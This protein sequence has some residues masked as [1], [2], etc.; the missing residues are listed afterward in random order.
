MVYI[1]QF[2]ILY[3]YYLSE[4]VTTV[5]IFDLLLYSMVLM[6]SLHVCTCIIEV[7]KWDE[8]R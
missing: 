3:S 7:I 8:T 1:K 2:W 6:R 4:N 5:C